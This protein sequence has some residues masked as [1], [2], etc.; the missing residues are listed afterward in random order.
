MATHLFFGLLFHGLLSHAQVSNNQQVSFSS[1]RDLELD[2]GSAYGLSP[3]TM[4][5]G[6]IAQSTV[7]NVMRGA[8]KRNPESL[9]FLGLLRLYGQGGMPEDQQK[10][11]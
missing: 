9:Y 2:L 8:Q 11:E 7:Q 5:E 6:G 4:E 1:M 10:G 3:W